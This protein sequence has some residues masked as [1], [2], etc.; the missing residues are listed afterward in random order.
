MNKAHQKKIVN[1]VIAFERKQ[2]FD[3]IDRGY[4]SEDWGQTELCHYLATQINPK[5]GKL[6]K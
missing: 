2:L 3:L 5:R 4:I 6:P 1:E